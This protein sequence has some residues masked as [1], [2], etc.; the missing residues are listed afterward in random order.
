VRYRRRLPRRLPNQ[1]KVGMTTVRATIKAVSTH[2]ICD[3][4]ARRLVI[5]VG[6]AIFTDPIIIEWV[7]QPRMI[8]RLMAHLAE[9]AVRLG[10]SGGG[11]P[12]VGRDRMTGVRGTLAT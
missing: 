4:S 8:D 10:T 1:P 2:W 9:G 7:R 3:T 5:I 6:R 12:G 11:P